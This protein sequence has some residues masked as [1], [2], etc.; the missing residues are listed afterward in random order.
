MP[1]ILFALEP[2]ADELMISYLY[3]LA[4]YNCIGSMSVF[5]V[6]YIFTDRV[7]RNNCWIKLDMNRV[8]YAYFEAEDTKIDRVQFYLDHS[9]YGGIAPL[10]P[11][12]QQMQMMNEAFGRQER[13]PRLNSPANSTI[14]ALMMCP[15]CEKED[16]ERIGKRY[17]HKLHHMPGVKVCAKHGCALYRCVSATPLMNR[18]ELKFEPV[19]VDDE[20]WEKR[21]ADFTS[22]FLNANIDTNLDRLVDAVFKRMQ[23][24]G[25]KNSA[26]Q[27]SDYRNLKRQIA[28]KKIRALLDMDLDKFLKETLIT[29][30]YIDKAAML[31]LLCFLF[32]SVEELKR[33]LDVDREL[34]L[35]FIEAAKKDYD[36][37]KPFRTTLVEMR[38]K[39]TEECFVTTAYGF[40]SGWRELSAD[41][42]LSEEEKFSEIF[43]NTT[44]GTYVQ[45]GE[46]KSIGDPV[47]MLHK[48]CGKKIHPRARAFLLDG[49]R[50]S[51]ES[52]FSFEK[53]AEMVEKNQGFHLLEYDGTERNCVILHDA[54]GRKFSCAFKK[55]IQ[56]PTCR[57][58]QL[59]KDFSL[60][61]LKEDVK[62]LVGDEYTVIEVYGGAHSHVTMRHETCGTTFNMLLGAFRHGSRCPQCQKTYDEAEFCKI[63]PGLSGGQYR[64]GKLLNS[65]KKRYEIIDTQ[66]GKTRRMEMEYVLQ[67]LLRSTPSDVL[68]LQKRAEAEA[69]LNKS[70]MIETLLKKQ[71][72]D[73]D[74][75]FLEDV[76]M[77][78]MPYSV[79]K[80]AFGTLHK[81]EKLYRHIEGIYS[82]TPFEVEPERIIREKYI[83]RNNR[84]IGFLYGESLAY[85]LGIIPEK[86]DTIYIVTNK[87]SLLHGRVRNVCGQK[88]R[89]RGSETPVTDDNY[90]ILQVLDMLRMRFKRGWDV[91]PK[92]KEFTEENKITLDNFAPYIELF[93]DHV[94]K[95]LLLLYNEGKNDAKDKRGYESP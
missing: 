79:V 35:R 44:D 86:P 81:K 3:R 66:T 42:E 29:R 14:D 34:A 50:C 25:Y 60:E 27:G 90:K 20:V 55:F 95:D 1:K 88:I 49:A 83:R 4:E 26:Y 63:V 58:C 33:Y 10:L 91:Y 48:V 37:F 77:P 12:G 92:L 5:L 59:G 67:E 39:D 45:S 85:E 40:I 72:A 70:A 82:L 78:D 76:W 94:K 84:A 80:R 31:S 74:L 11:V 64:V 17:F 8:F 73:T 54:C 68:S 36:V 56:F 62:A 47:E 38:R 16:R 13:F 57:K 18:S 7:N 15:E 87:E 28:E 69:E 65:A 41:A 89:I 75:I 19:S 2:E 53:A 71:Y 24:L 61:G 43:H 21:Y 22:D 46:F 30:K 23:E 9:I 52:K 6:S 32:G 51:C 93:S